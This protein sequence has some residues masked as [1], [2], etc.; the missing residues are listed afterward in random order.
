ML[1][2]SLSRIVKW[3][4]NRKYHNRSNTE[5]NDGSVDAQEVSVDSASLQR[6]VSGCVMCDRLTGQGDAVEVIRNHGADVTDVSREAQAQKIPVLFATLMNLC[7]L[8][9]S[10][11][12][13]TPTKV[14][15]TSRASRRQRERR[16]RIQS[17][18]RHSGTHS[19]LSPHHFVCSASMQTEGG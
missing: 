12:A 2:L 6:G 5:N 17:G 4:S 18:I 15:R 10:G 1:R 7:H 16:H 14:Q 9:Q 13:K 11:L 3:E 19:I 8:K